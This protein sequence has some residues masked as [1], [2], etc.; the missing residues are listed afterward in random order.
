MDNIHRFKDVSE[1]SKEINDQSNDWISG[2]S[3]HSL[4]AI[5]AI[6]AANCAIAQ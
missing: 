2:L 5:Y 3:S 4:Q 6:I 1:A